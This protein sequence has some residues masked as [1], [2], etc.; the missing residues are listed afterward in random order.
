M[1][2]ETL[3][4]YAVSVGKT[5]QYSR[6]SDC[7]VF[8]KLMPWNNKSKRVIFNLTKNFYLSRYNLQYPLRINLKPTI[9]D[10]GL[11]SIPLVISLAKF[12]SVIFPTISTIWVTQK[13]N[14]YHRQNNENLNF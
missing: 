2:E 14:Y 11:I 3:K 10:Y 13:N 7:K 12:L 4:D 1:A 9:I 8:S 6:K 5:N